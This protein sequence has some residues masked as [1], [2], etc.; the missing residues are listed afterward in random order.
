MHGRGGS[1][2]LGDTYYS[3]HVGEK[4]PQ[5]M[6]YDTG[7]YLHPAG[8]NPNPLTAQSKRFINFVLLAAVAQP[9]G[10]RNGMWFDGKIRIWP[11]VDTVLAK[12]DSKNHK[13]GTLI[14][15]QTTINWERHEKLMIE[16]VTHTIKATSRSQDLHKAGLCKATQRED[17]IQDVPGDE[18]TLETQPANSPDLKVNDLDSFHSIK[19]L[20][21]DV[22]VTIGDELV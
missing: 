5:V 17:A 7:V 22:G 13:K 9:R 15:K 19:Q 1:R 3:I 21:Y 4:W 11:V 2:V 12:R 10:T 8:N 16:E 6:K 20:N 18:I 14:M